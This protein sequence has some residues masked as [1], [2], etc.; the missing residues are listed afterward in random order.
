[1]LLSYSAFV[2]FILFPATP[3]WWATEYG[4]LTNGPVTLTHFM[5]P[6][7]ALVA[8]PNPVAAFPSLHAAYPVY[9]ALWGTM[10]WGRR[11]QWLWI[12]P[13]GV[14]FAAVYLGHHYVV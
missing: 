3:P 4:Y 7:L 12:L 8:S 10:A 11:A 13:L 6:S 14:A 5:F 2:T 9:I 1:M